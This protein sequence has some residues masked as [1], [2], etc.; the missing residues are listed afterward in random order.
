MGWVQPP[1]S[2]REGLGSNLKLGIDH[3]YMRFFVIFFSF[4]MQKCR[5]NTSTKPRLR[6][7]FPV[8]HPV[9]HILTL[10]LC[11]PVKSK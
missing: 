1:L 8:R 2:P 7:S 9:I 4:S 5:V 10:S 6:V 3:L 11:K